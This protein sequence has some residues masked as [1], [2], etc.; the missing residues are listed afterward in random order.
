MSSIIICSIARLFLFTLILVY[1]SCSKPDKES[2]KPPGVNAGP[3]QIIS[4]PTN[5]TRLVGSAYDPDGKIIEWHWAY[6]SGPSSFTL[7]HSN[8]PIALVSNL[9]KGSYVFELTAKDNGGLIVK[10]RIIIDVGHPPIAK[11]GADMNLIGSCSSVMEKV[12]VDPS[13][14]SDLDNDITSYNWRQISGPKQVNLTP[15]LFPKTQVKDLGIGKT[16]IELSVIDGIGLISK[17][18]IWIDV[19]A[20]TSEY[21]LDMQVLASYMFL[22]KLEICPWECYYADLVSIS[23]NFQ[24]PSLGQMSIRIQE[25]TDTSRISYNVISNYS[26]FRLSNTFYASGM[27][28]SFKFKELIRQGGGSFS[29]TISLN[30]GSALA[31]NDN[32]FTTLPPLTVTGTLDTTTKNVTMRI[33]GKFLF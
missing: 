9:V 4:L 6:I 23:T 25:E 28:S 8:S 27:N 2:N 24:L 12:L 11:A 22:P 13:G 7:E 30:S 33:K 15:T 29:G 19:S 3:K 26:S 20:S 1:T 14:S 32:I 21:E 31:C 10:N 17:D 5:N 16:A 18:T